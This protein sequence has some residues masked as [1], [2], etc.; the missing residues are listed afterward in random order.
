MTDHTK[1]PAE[2]LLDRVEWRETNIQASEVK[3]E[4]DLPCA[5]HEGVLELGDMKLRCY[6]LSNGQTIIN[7][8]DMNE[9]F[10]ILD[11]YRDAKK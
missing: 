2:T 8:D 6:R 11:G 4:S 5:T 9:F 10:G 1:T 3:D 7:A